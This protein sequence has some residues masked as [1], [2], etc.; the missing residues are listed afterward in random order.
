MAPLSMVSPT[1]GPESL[2]FVRHIS[3]THVLGVGT[4][5]ARRPD[6][7]WRSDFAA[8]IRCGHACSLS[9]GR[10]RVGADC[11]CRTR[12]PVRGGVASHCINDLR[13]AAGTWHRR[14]R[15]EDFSLSHAETQGA[16]EDPGPRGSRQRR[17]GLRA[18]RHAW[19][20]HQGSPRS[21]RCSS[22]YSSFSATLLRSSS[23]VRMSVSRTCGRSRI[24]AS[25]S[26]SLDAR[27]ISA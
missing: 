4:V 3:V 8:A 18:S 24:S 14:S 6:I 21:W 27:V 5:I 16:R 11:A 22:F 1:L 10:F 9:A 20:V 26:A 12:T 23:I 19:G 25:L 17:K 13:I 2:K 7:V 15:A